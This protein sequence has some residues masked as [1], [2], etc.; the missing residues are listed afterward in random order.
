MLSAF[1]TLWSWYA[2][3]MAAI[4][5]QRVLGGYMD[6]H[7]WPPKLVKFE[8][9][10]LL[11]LGDT[12]GGVRSFSWT[13]P[14]YVTTCQFQWIVRGTDV[15]TFNQN[16]GSNRGDRVRTNWTMKEELLQALYPGF[17]QKELLTLNG[18]AVAFTGL[19]ESVLWSQ[20]TFTLKSDRESG[21]LYQIATVRVTD[22]TQ[23]ILN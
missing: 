7:D 9:V 15:S 16:L 13:V 5:P 3:R 18:G 19:N 10:Y 1:D 20:P 2:Q 14:F 6:A 21:L 23:A 22:M 4:N 17:A 11:S 12:P 8:T